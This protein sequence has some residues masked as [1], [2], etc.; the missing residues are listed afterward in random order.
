MASSPVSSS[1]SSVRILRR[2]TTRSGKPAAA[3]FN[4][5]GPTP[6]SPRRRAAAR[7]VDTGMVWRLVIAAKPPT[8]DTSSGTNRKRPYARNGS[9]SPHVDKSVTSGVA[10]G[11]G[12]SS[13]CASV[14]TP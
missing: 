13:S 5:G 10:L 8:V 9:R 1:S 6:S 12:S 2:D 14:G 11:S 4:A 3:D 7:R